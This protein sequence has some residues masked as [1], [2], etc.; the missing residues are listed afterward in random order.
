MYAFAVADIATYLQ[1]IFKGKVDSFSNIEPKVEARM[2]SC[3][4]RYHEL[5]LEVQ[6]L[7]H[8]DSSFDQDIWI[9]QG[10]FVTDE[11]TTPI[12]VLWEFLVHELFKLF[13]AIKIDRVPELGSTMMQKVDTV[14]VHVFFVPAKHGFPRADVD[15]GVGDPRY[16]L[17]TKSISV[18]KGRNFSWFK[19]WHFDLL[20][21]GVYLVEIPRDSFVEQSSQNI[22]TVHRR[23]ILQ[24][25]PEL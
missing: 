7:H 18:E 25:F 5:I 20:Q 23:A 3:G 6:A 19:E 17:F 2:I 13:V 14:Q 10:C 24:W 11:L 16:F 12:W 1:P 21:Y 22:S 8:F 9:D 15:V 4:T